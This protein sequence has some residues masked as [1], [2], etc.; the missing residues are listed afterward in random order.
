MQTIDFEPD[1]EMDEADL[2]MLKVTFGKEEFIIPKPTTGQIMLVMD[3]MASR[4]ISIRAGAVLGFFRNLDGGLG[5]VI[6]AYLGNGRIPDSEV[7][8][9][10]FFE[11]V[12]EVVSEGTPTSSAPD[13]TSSRASGGQ[14]STAPVRRP[15]TTRSTSRPRASSTSS[16][17]G[18]SRS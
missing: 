6:E 8:T 16:S 7:R 4:S 15:A 12:M 9:L 3:K 1:D 14:T 10:A 18:S 5:D 11:K 17:G 13:S 2:D